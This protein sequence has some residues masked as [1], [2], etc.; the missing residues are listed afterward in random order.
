[1]ERTTWLGMLMVVTLTGCAGLGQHQ[2]LARMQSQVG[3]LDER[4]TQ[5]ERSGI[6]GGSGGA[7]L[8]GPAADSG[9]SGGTS[10]QSST[11]SLKKS[12]AGASLKPSTSEIQRALKNAGFYQGKVDGKSGPLTK[13]AVKE[14]QRV[15]GLTDDGVVGRKT[16]AKLQA[17]ADLSGSGDSASAGTY[18]K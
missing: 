18:V 7:A 2:E 13:E 4:V 6:S 3:I 11:P 17:Y 15:H 10:F 1:M 8:P 12:A 14:F 16:W 9:L 5:L